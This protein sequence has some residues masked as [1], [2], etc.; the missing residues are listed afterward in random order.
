MKHFKRLSPK[1]KSIQTQ[2]KPPSACS[3]TPTNAN[4]REPLGYLVL[5]TRTGRLKNSFVPGELSL[6][7]LGDME[8]KTM[9]YSQNKGSYGLSLTYSYHADTG[10]CL[11]AVSRHV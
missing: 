3:G 2:G 6:Q 4:G 11:L 7:W 5:R 9:T 10:L 8:Y 1:V